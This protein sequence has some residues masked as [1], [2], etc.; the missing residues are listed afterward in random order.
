M[1]VKNHKT[2]SVRRQT[3]LLQVNRAMLYYKRGEREEDFILSQK[4][5]EIYLQYP[6]YGYRRITAMISRE[7]FRANRKRSTD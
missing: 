4:I 7:G 5:A 1:V 2:V 3:V 6:M